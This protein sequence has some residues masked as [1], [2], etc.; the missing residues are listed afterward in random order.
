[1]TAALPV[2]RPAHVLVPPAHPFRSVLGEEI[3][4]HVRDYHAA[5]NVAHPVGKRVRGQIEPGRQPV[6]LAGRGKLHL[7]T[8]DE[9]DEAPSGREV[10]RATDDR[11]PILDRDSPAL[12]EDVPD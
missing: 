9:I 10:L 3:P 6:H 2:S 5:A 12:W 11:D 1:M 7:G 4:I 8:A